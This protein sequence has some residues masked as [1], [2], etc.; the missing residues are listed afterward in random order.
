[1]KSLILDSSFI[2]FLVTDPSYRLEDVAAKIPSFEMVVLDSVIDELKKLSATI[3]P[4]RAKSA[5]RALEYALMLKRVP[6]K[7]GEDV[8][9]IIL[10]YA[11]ST[12]SIV[13]T[14]DSKLRK[15]L[16]KIGVA[17]ISRS[18]NRLIFEGI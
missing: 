9:S 5:K 11:Y 10:N 2:I 4:K 7:K 15:Q 1:M 18:G 3:P 16:R 6:Y 14:M 12:G 8:D 13:A 17:V